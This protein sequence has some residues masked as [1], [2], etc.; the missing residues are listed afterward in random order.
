M[1]WTPIPVRSWPARDGTG[2]PRRWSVQLDL[3]VTGN[4]SGTVL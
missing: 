2:C 4:G 1:T 3:V